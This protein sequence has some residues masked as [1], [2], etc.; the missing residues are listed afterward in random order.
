MLDRVPAQL[1]P[2]IHEEVLAAIQQYVRGE[3]IEFGASIVLAS[4][5]K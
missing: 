5:S 2:K 1:W 4:G 3:N